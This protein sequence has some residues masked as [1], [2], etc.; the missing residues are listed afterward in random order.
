MSREAGCPYCVIED[1]RKRHNL[2]CYEAAQEQVEYLKEEVTRSRSALREWLA[3]RKEAA[4]RAEAGL[5]R[6]EASG[7]HYMQLFHQKEAECAVLEE[8]LRNMRRAH[9]EEYRCGNRVKILCWRLQ[10][11]LRAHRLMHD[12]D[13]GPIGDLLGP[14]ALAIYRE[15]FPG[16]GE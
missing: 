15:I 2:A 6:G 8:E 4:E 12:K 11:V 9:A 3:S 7:M 1:A 10:T 13:A 14:T 16:H 5:A